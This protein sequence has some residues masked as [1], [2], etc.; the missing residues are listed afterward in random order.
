MDA[1]AAGILGTSIVVAALAGALALR[2]PAS[3]SPVSE[4]GIGRF[5]IGTNLGH[6]YVI[7]TATGQVWETFVSANQGSNDAEFKSPKVK[8]H[9]AAAAK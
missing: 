4:P 3:A 1:K 5:Q 9:A 2:P 6:S 8:D 7:D